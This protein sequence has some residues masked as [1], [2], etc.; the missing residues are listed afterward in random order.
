MIFINVTGGVKLADRGIDLAIC[1]A[2]AS[3]FLILRRR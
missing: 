1:L 3:S 2:V